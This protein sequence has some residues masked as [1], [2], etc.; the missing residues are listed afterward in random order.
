M[1]VVIDTNSLLF[2]VRYYLCF[3]K[4]G[5]LIKFFK[6]KIATG[7][8]IIIDEVLKECKQI[9]KGVILEK[10]D[11]LN[12]KEFLNSTPTPYRTDSLIAPSPQKFLR[13]LENS[14]VN[15][16][17]K[18]SKGINETEFEKMKEEFLKSAD[19]RQII[20]CLNLKNEKEK[21]VILVTEETESSNDNKLFKK[22][23]A[24]CKILDIET[25]TLPQLLEKYEGINID[26][27]SK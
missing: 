9:S 20:L 19:M 14:F 22:I 26:F 16:V 5:L 25:M 1:I 17:I 24:I 7:E 18:S 11:F 10:L 4:S 3:D 13:Q 15:I 6:T 12:D 27:Q 8:I 21:K 2:L 23:P